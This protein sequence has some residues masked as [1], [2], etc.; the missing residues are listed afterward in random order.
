M[1]RMRAEDQAAVAYAAGWTLA[2]APRTARLTEGCIAAAA[3]AAAFP[4]DPGVTETT[5]QIGK[6]DGTWAVFFRRRE[7]LIAAHAR[8]VLTA[9]SGPLAALRPG[10]AIAGYHADIAAP[11]G[12]PDPSAARDTGADAAAGII[13]GLYAS[14]SWHK[15]DLAFLAALRAA[16]AEGKAG[17]LAIAAAGDG[18]RVTARDFT[19]ACRA[20]LAAGADAPGPAAEAAAWLDRILQAIARGIGQLLARLAL[21]GQDAAEIEAEVTAQLAAAGDTIAARAIRLYLDQAMS[22]AMTRASLDLYAAEGQAE[23]SFLTAGDSRVCVT[24]EQAEQDSPYPVGDG[25]VPGLHPLCRCVVVPQDPLPYQR[26]AA[27]Y[28]TAA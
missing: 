19:A 7:D 6:L 4:G 17:V 27:R 16:A 12:D 11:W 21:D 15:I 3:T 25:P 23:Y 1:T 24:C 10:S 14:T 28:L 22:Q 9:F 5:L 8:A 20:F 26:L 18:L 13:A 2:G